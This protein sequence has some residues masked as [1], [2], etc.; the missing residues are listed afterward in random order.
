MQLNGVDRKIIILVLII[1]A[2]ALSVSIHAVAADGDYKVLVYNE[3]VTV[4]DDRTVMV[5]LDYNFSWN[6]DG[7]IVRDWSMNI[8]SGDAYGIVVENDNGPLPFTSTASANW[9]SL[10]ID[11]MQDVHAGQ[12]YMFKVSYLSQDNIQSIGPE[13][14]LSMWTISDNVPKD[15]VSLT[16]KIPNSYGVVNWDPQF[17]TETNNANETVLNGQ[18]ANVSAD[19][20]LML[21][22]NYATTEVR[23]DIVYQYLFNNTGSS[24][25]FGSEFELPIYTQSVDQENTPY[26]SIPAPVSTWNDSSENLRANYTFAQIGPGDIANITVSYQTEIMLPPT[27]DPSSSGTL[28]DIPSSYLGYTSA[29]KYWEIN[30]PAIVSLSQNLTRNE[31]T[32]LGMV[33]SIYNFTTTNISYDYVK[34]DLIISGVSVE[35]YGAVK[36]L[37]LGMGV[38]EDITDL[39][40]TLCRAAGIPAIE[41]TGPIYSQD[42][43]MGIGETHAW[44]DVYVPGYGW[45]EVDPTWKEFGTLDG[46]HIAESTFSN[47]S[48]PD[49]IILGNFRSGTYEVL[50]YITMVT[51]SSLYLA[52]PS[53]TAVAVGDLQTGTPIDLKVLVSNF[54]NGTAYS[55]NVTVIGS[56][57]LTVSNASISFGNVRGYD[58]ETASLVASTETAGNYSVVFNLKYLTDAGQAVNQSYICNFL[59]TKKPAFTLDELASSVNDMIWMGLGVGFLIALVAILAVWRTKRSGF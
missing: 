49:W 56:A 23:Y 59:V 9:T 24:T 4:L 19:T 41:I 18:A 58:T 17:M 45:L 34:Y 12:T 1:F 38:C 27:I 32:V 35:R 5:S 26:S 7:Y 11:L 6:Q 46:R 40:V 10:D 43:L 57:N 55:T 8:P 37:S 28:S 22:V 25:D 53:I 2:L 47:S 14:D 42:G 15:S 31:Q 48:E 44:A 21:N 52:N 54:G 20:N 3:T 33:K 39:F 51:S 30:D 13:R 50:T 36:T 16:V 29:D